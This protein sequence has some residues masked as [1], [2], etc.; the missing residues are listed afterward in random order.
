S[1]WS[2]P[3]RRAAMRARLLPFGCWNRRM[4]TGGGAA[5]YG[6]PVRHMITTRS[7]TAT[8]AWLAESPPP[9]TILVGEKTLGAPRAVARLLAPALGA[10]TVV[11]PGAAHDSAHEPA[12]GRRRFALPPYHP[13]AG[14]VYSP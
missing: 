12:C 10:A 9:T 3:T 4:A 6:H 7:D 1:L 2:S 11:V 14:S 8:L 5:A 13:S